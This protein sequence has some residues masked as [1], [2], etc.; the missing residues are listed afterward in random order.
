MNYL[1]LDQCRDRYLYRLRSRNLSVGV[2]NAQT[3]GFTGIR[4]K[5]GDEFL[6]TEYHWDTGAP[7]GTACPIEELKPLPSDIELKESLGSVD[8]DSGRP[9]AF[10]K[11]VADGG[12]GW[13]FL[14]DGEASSKIF[15]CSV[16]NKKLFNWLKGWS[17]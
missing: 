17:Q 8:D 7:H 6:D 5:F 1:S 3:K 11:P 15:P 12:K 14:D 13:Y 2:Y 4:Q 16:G 9:V 10:D